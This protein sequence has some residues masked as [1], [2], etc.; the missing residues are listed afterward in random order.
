M[1]AEGGIVAHQPVQSLATCV[2]SSLLLSLLAGCGGF[3]SSESGPLGASCVDDSAH[4]VRERQGALRQMVADTNRSWVAAPPTLETHASGVR[5]FAFKARKK[6]LTCHE[7]AVG[8]REAEGAPAVLRA[9]AGGRLS[10]SQ[11]ARASL[12]AREVA[13]ELAAE[14]RRRCG[15]G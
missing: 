7:L 8:R 10:S 15:K 6:D 2:L 11:V 1:E 14:Q 4:C 9:N 5:L 13:A 3:G 12:L